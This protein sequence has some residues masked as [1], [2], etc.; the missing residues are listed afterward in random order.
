V[1]N[2]WNSGWWKTLLVPGGLVLALASLI[3]SGEVWRVSPTGLSFFYSVVFLAG[4]VLA[5]RFHSGRTFAAM[6]LVLLAHRAVEFFSAGRVAAVGPGRTALEGVSILLAVNI[7][8][9]AAAGEF[10][11]TIAAFAPRLG[12]LF[13]ESVFIAVICRPR[14]EWGSD[15]FRAAWLPQSWFAWTKLS[16]VSWLA[17]LVAFAFLVVRSAFSRKQSD[18]GF[19][20]ALAAVAC[21]LSGGGVGRAADGYI[22]TAGFVLLVSVVE[23]SYRMA[24]HDEL[25]GIPSRR[26]LNDA[27]AGLEFPYTVAVVDIDH[28]KNFNDTYGHDTGDEVLRMVA[29]RLAGVTGGGKAFRVG[30]E[31]FT[32]LFAGKR[33]AEVQSHLERLRGTIEETKFHLRGVDRRVVAR[34]PER[35]SSTR[36]AGR[37][38]AGDGP[39]HT[40]DLRVTVSIGAAEGRDG[41]TFE[42][43]HDRA[44]KALYR[45]KKNGRNRLEVDENQNRAKRARGKKASA[46]TA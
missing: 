29:G 27:R 9:L 16:Q 7:T 11:F 1:L 39:T 30:G 43:A 35:R 36:T 8:W 25:T 20:W 23:T 6:I 33:V 17:L 45:A 37:A 38:R 13:L 32:L 40:V 42:E 31:E 21:A 14:P 15:L 44:D 41:Q 19:A 3:L 28:F 10:G 12:I 22:A 5:W 46:K 4:L 18:A 24:Y 26:A 34:G 2:T